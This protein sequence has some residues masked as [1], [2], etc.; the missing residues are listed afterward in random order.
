MRRHGIDP[1]SVTA[2]H[3]KVYKAALMQAGRSSASIARA[4]SVLRGAYQQFG[5][6]GLVEWERVRDIQGV[7]SPRVEK[8]LTPA[9]SE[10]EAKMLL[11]APDQ[12]TLM[13][14]RDHAMLFVFF[15]T[16]CRCSAIANA[17]VGY[18]ER[19]DT[20][21]YLVVFEKGNKRQRKALLEAAAPLFAYLTAAGIGDDREGPLFR[22]VNKDR[23]TLLR[24]PLD[25][26]TIWKTVK[27]YAREVGIDVDRLGGRGV[28]VHSLRK[29]AITNA[30][31]H[32]ARMEQVQQLAG[33]AQITTTQ[34][35]FAPKD[36]D[37][38]DA[39]RHIQIR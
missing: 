27:K 19:T 21:H 16:A 8:N 4:L 31:E 24:K 6:Y 14:L 18:I 25:R 5:R 20:E 12:T 10:T 7:A 17:K 33:H 39:A 3:I 30:L 34:M 32:G 29:T 15:K 36:R 1:L 2:D 9:L 22:P 26:R 28:G 35:Y 13:G 38:E 11:H 23:Q 37:A